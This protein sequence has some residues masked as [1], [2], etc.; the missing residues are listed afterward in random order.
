[1]SYWLKLSQT[2]SYTAIISPP[3]QTAQFGETA[4]ETAAM[5]WLNA[6]SIDAYRELLPLI[7]SCCAGTVLGSKADLEGH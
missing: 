4:A 3:Y 6:N 1:M 5:L 7:C 2:I